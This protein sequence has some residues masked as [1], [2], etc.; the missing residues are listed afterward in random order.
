MRHI[1]DAYQLCIPVV[2]LNSFLVMIP[3]NNFFFFVCEIFDY[4]MI[5]QFS[6]YD[7][8]FISFFFWLKM[9]TLYLMIENWEVFIKFCADLN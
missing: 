6:I 5:T 4:R 8:N 3:T 9:T 7:D 2:L 1:C